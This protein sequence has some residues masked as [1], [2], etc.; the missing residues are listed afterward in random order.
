MEGLQEGISLFSAQGQL[1]FCNQRLL[2]LLQQPTPEQ[3]I[4]ALQTLAPELRTYG[5]KVVLCKRPQGQV[6]EART[7]T[8][9]DGGVLCVVADITQRQ[10]RQEHTE[11]LANHDALTGLLNRRQFEA[12][13]GS[14]IALAHRL[15]DRFAVLYFDL[16][17]F[18]PINDTYGHAMG[19]LVLVHVAQVLRE[20]VRQ[21]DYSAR[22]GGDEFAVL[23]RGVEHSVQVLTLAQRLGAVLSEPWQ[24]GS[25]HLHIGA[26]IGL[27]MYPEHGQTPQ[28]LLVAADRA[29]YLAKSNS[30]ASG[31]LAPRW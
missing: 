23:L 24:E 28:A 26:S 21:C 19:D 7:I 3:A 27:A 14:E 10:Q 2:E 29:M 22:V 13:L 12:Y 31:S 16:D 15:H 30:H 1:E 9:H 11:Y 4:Q 25:V 6:L 18:K 17:R 20:T 5:D 8:V